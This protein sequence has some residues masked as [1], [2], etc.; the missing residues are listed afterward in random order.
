MPEPEIEFHP[1][2]ARWPPFSAVEFES[3]KESVRTWGVLRPITLYEGKILDGRHRYM[4]A[5]AVGARFKTVEYTG[6]DPAGFV[7]AMNGSRRVLKPMDRAL[8]ALKTFQAPHG[9][10]KLTQKEIALCVGVSVRTVKRAKKKWTGSRKYTKRTEHADKP[11]NEGMPA[12]GA[13]VVAFL[14]KLLLELVED[15][16]V[17]GNILR[18]RETQA[19][20]AHL[21]DEQQRQIFEALEKAAPGA[22]QEAVGPAR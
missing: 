15:S 8:V 13:L 3:L 18:L 2:A 20:I 12:L 19:L 6:E 9:G 5:K 10:S 21:S 7:A 16:V 11:A 22:V 1:L 17:R 4:A 14:L